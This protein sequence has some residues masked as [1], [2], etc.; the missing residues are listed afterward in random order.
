MEYVKLASGVK[1]FTM[2]YLVVADIPAPSPAIL[3]MY[4]GLAC[5]AGINMATDYGE[6]ALFALMALSD[7]GNGNGVVVGLVGWSS[8][9]SRLFQ[10]EM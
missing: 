8:A 6:A 3:Q 9:I 7:K 2:P 5:L 1:V 4:M 10:A